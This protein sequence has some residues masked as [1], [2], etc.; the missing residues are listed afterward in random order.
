VFDDTPR[1]DRLPMS[2]TLLSTR[3]KLC[4]LT[5]S[6]G[7]WEVRAAPNSNE[8][9]IDCSQLTQTKVLNINGL[10]PGGYPSSYKAIVTLHN[11]GTN[12]V[13]PTSVEYKY[14]YILQQSV[15]KPVV[16]VDNIVFQTNG[17]DVI[18][19]RETATT[20]FIRSLISH[21]N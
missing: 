2:Y 16:D 3:T 15:T 18:E 19:I 4:I 20:I 14:N 9:E 1:G 11:A 13:L 17:I 6:M 10:L 21:S 7:D 8:T 5:D 12:M